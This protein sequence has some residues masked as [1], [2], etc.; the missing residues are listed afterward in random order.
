VSDANDTLPARVF[1][2]PIG[3]PLTIGMS[4]LTIASFVESGLQLHWIVSS[5]ATEVGL[6]L[7]AVPFTLQLI[8]CVF[9]YLA[10]DGA[11]GAAVGVLATTWLATGL[12][13]LVSIPGQRSGALGLTL[14][15][16]AGALALSAAAVATTKPLPATVFLAAAVRFV[17]A[18]IYELSATGLWQNASGVVGLVVTV[19]AG[20]CI[21]AFEL[22]SQS[23]APILPTFRRGRGKS[24]LHDGASAQLGGVAQEAG[25]RQT[26]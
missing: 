5:Q 4:G 24:A 8:A 18:G 1:L 7:V 6:I 9:A 22:E 13:H 16:S 19:I 21:V 23:H 17:L 10:R 14:L 26:S 11:A 12:V 3:A 2:R 25:V 15:A 20:Y